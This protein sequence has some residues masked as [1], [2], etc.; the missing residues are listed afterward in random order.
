[1]DRQV[2]NRR[3]ARI[4]HAVARDVVEFLSADRAVYAAEE[5]AEVLAGHVQTHGQHDVV[6]ARSGHPRVRRARAARAVAGR[7]GLRRRRR[8]GAALLAHVVL[9]RR[10]GEGVVP[11]RV[12]E[13]VLVERRAARG[14][15]EDVDL[16]ARTRPGR[17]DP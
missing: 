11:A 4:L 9:A 7:E 17:P 15:V 8:R 13:D 14:L 2:R 6:A 5:V 12:G 10:N 3:I 1:M 16:E